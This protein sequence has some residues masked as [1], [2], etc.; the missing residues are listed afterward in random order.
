MHTLISFL[1]FAA[2]TDPA[3]IGK[4]ACSVAGSGAIGCGG[5]SLLAQGGFVANAINTVLIIVGA[6]S[7]I[8]VIVGGL[9]YTLSGGDSA[10]L[11]SAKDTIMYA[12]IGL[13]IT[14]L[15]FAIV[16][17]VINKLG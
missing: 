10:G 1:K 8:M 11:K 14:L 2:N 9:R 17:F 5:T 13:A 16:S 15:S 4:T 6:L 12:L 7:V 3:N